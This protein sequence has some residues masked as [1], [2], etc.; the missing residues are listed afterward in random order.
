[1]CIVVCE[2]YE[3]VVMMKNMVVVCVLM[4]ISD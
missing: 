1:M 3:I 2:D 4:F